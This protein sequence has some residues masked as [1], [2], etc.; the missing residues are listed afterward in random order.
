[1]LNAVKPGLPLLIQSVDLRLIV[2]PQGLELPHILVLEGQHVLVLH[3]VIVHNLRLPTIAGLC[4]II[5]P[6]P[7]GIILSFNHGLLRKQL[8]MPSAGH[9]HSLLFGENVLSY[10]VHSVRKLFSHYPVSSEFL[11]DLF[12]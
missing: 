7:D 8:L 2:M 9:R 3:Y 10:R 11:V 1:M 6:H 4:Q 12:F 5:K